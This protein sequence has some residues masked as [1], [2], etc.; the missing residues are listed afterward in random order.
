MY[1]A[2]NIYI[3]LTGFLGGLLKNKKVP[4]GHVEQF[5]MGHVEQVS[6]V[7]HCMGYIEQLLW[8]TLDTT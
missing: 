7:P 4:V 5:F 1:E 6:N 2:I 3:G 8:G